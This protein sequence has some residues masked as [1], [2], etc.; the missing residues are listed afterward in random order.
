M[1]TTP[2]V[3]HTKPPARFDCCEVRGGNPGG[4]KQGGHSNDGVSGPRDVEDFMGVCRMVG[5]SALV[6]DAHPNSLR[7]SR[8]ALGKSSVSKASNP[9]WMPCSRRWR[10]RIPIAVPILP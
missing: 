1:G 9:C 5:V 10:R 2:G 3:S 7:V 6:P 8:M 4:Q